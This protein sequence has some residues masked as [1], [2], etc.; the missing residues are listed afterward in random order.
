[1]ASATRPNR[2]GSPEKR[3][4][5]DRLDG[6]VPD[7]HVALAAVLLNRDWDWAGGTG[8]D[9]AIALEPADIP[10]RARGSVFVL[11]E[12]MGRRRSHPVTKKESSIPL[13]E[14]RVD[15]TRAYY[16]ARRYDLAAEA[17]RGSTRPPPSGGW[18]LGQVLTAQGSMPAP[19]APWRPAS[20][21]PAAPQFR[22]FGWGYGRAGRK[23]EAKASSPAEEASQPVSNRSI[24][25]SRISASEMGTRLSRTLTRP[26]R[27]GTAG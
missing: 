3:A 26:L 25:P 18:G 6:T 8:A 11:P 4:T 19:S 12:V 13:G 27:S 9:A 10:E 16:F 20:N 15:L 24:S 17:R 22:G 1:M 7:G 23:A 14:P 5:R 2:G 21:L